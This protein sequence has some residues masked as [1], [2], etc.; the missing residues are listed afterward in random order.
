MHGYHLG[1][2]LIVGGTDLVADLAQLDTLASHLD[3]SVLASHESEFVTL[4]LR[5]VGDKVSSLV[6]TGESRNRWKASVQE[7]FLRLVRVVEI[8]AGHNRA[9]D[10]ELAHGADGHQNTWVARINYPIVA[11]YG[12]TND[13][14]TCK[15]SRPIVISAHDTAF[16]WSIGVEDLTA[17]APFLVGSMA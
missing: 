10:K 4:A 16:S 9:L 8:S 7:G 5:A 6:C 17:L 3:L 11:T 14:R 1:R 12:A 13:L 15:K 2:Y